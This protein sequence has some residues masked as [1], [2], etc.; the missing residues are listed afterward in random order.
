MGKLKLGNVWVLVQLIF[1]PRW[2]MNKLNEKSNIASLSL[3]LPINSAEEGSDTTELE[4]GATATA[5]LHTYS[6]QLCRA[7]GEGR[8]GRPEHTSEVAPIKCDGR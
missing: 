1:G 5:T 4:G 7:S 3:R 6:H 8:G 2:P